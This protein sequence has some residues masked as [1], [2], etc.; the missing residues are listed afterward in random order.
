MEPIK[1]DKL[2]IL[3]KIIEAVSHP[4]YVGFGQL[5]NPKIKINP[6]VSMKG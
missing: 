4:S 5:Y 1:L 2:I 6:R 3:K